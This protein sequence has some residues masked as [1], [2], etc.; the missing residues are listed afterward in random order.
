MRCIYSGRVQIPH[1]SYE[2]FRKTLMQIPAARRAAK[3][4]ASLTDRWGARATVLYDAKSDE[5]YEKASKRKVIDAASAREGA[6]PLT[7]L[8]RASMLGDD[9]K[10]LETMNRLQLQNRSGNHR[11]RHRKVQVPKQYYGGSF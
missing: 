7:E 11:S 10:F 6:I 8:G 1:E 3:F 9:E 2:Q 5:F 4:R